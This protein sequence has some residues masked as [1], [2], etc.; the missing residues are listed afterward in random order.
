M[1][2]LELGA[3]SK[4][5]AAL[6]R[7]LSPG[8]AG[9]DAA[10]GNIA[11][12]RRAV[13]EFH[14]REGD[15]LTLA[16]LIVF[17]TATHPIPSALLGLSTAG[18]DVLVRDMRRR[19]TLEV[20]NSFVR[21]R[22]KGR[23]AGILDQMPDDAG[24]VA[25]NAMHFKDRWKKEFDQAGTRPMVFHRRRGDFLDVPMMHSGEG[26]FRFR[27]DERFIAAELPYNTERYKLVMVTSK[28]GIASAREFAPMMDWLNGQGFE[29]SQGEVI[30][31]RFSTHETSDLLGPL[32]RLGLKTARL[33]QKPFRGFSPAQ[34]TISRILQKTELQI[35]EQGTE[36]SA[37]TGV[38][39][40]TAASPTEY[41]KM[42]V[43]RPFVFALRDQESG[44][45]LMMGYVTKPEVKA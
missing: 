13:R 24:L 16:N 26:R 37:S 32:D 10:A 23:I 15:V 14:G 12:L 7:V 2:L 22:T 5:R 33:S 25:I 3:S 30:M 38:A 39:F 41:V 18:T 27:Q 4:M 8:E 19:D 36:A 45:I 40:V 1:A 6:R 34:Q 9:S 43:D 28:T 35:D 42:V 21:D 11:Q 29:E 31:P 20:V 17:D 44:I